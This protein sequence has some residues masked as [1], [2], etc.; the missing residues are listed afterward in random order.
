MT[1]TSNPPRRGNE[2][3][4]LGAELFRL[5]IRYDDR[6]AL[7]AIIAMPL[8]EFVDA[9][10][11]EEGGSQSIGEVIAQQVAAHR[12][13]LTAIGKDILF[14]RQKAKHEEDCARWEAQSEAVKQ[15]KW[16][17]ARPTRDQR[18]RMIRTADQLQIELPGELTRGE[19]H[20]WIRDHGGNLRY[21]KE[22]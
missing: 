18:I 7:R 15:G 2:L 5:G 1:T 12:D 10:P 13:R 19:A 22:K 6:D 8:D 3:A 20:D 17:A 11:N 16:R 9:F 14:E 4:T 21:N